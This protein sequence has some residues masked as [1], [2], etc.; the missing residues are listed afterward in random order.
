M[1][2]VALTGADFYTGLAAGLFFPISVDVLLIF[3]LFLASLADLLAAGFGDS[4]G[5]DLERPLS[6]GFRTADELFLSGTTT[7][8][9]FSG[10]DTVSAGFA[11]ATFPLGTDL[12]LDFASLP[13]FPLSAV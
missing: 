7:A 9:F 10:A 2:P 1:A 3:L 11:A 6:A 13:F 12:D 5:L 8:F 4:L